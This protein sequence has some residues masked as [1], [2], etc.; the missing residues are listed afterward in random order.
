MWFTGIDALVEKKVK[1][2]LACQASTHPPKSYMEPQKMSKLPDGPWQKIAIDFCG[3]FP[4]GD[5][6]LVAIYEFIWFPEVEV[7][8]ST[9]AYSQSSTRCSALIPEE[10]K[11]DN[12][13]PFQNTDFKR[14]AEH[15]GFEHRKITPDWSQANSEAE[16]FMRTLEK[17]VCCAMIE[18]K[19]WK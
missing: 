1:I 3:P 14:F 12:G 9:S 16:R 2:C 10:I 19:G 5:Y 8:K 17:A 11:S 13:P 15:S 4:S 18:G 7:T 6:L